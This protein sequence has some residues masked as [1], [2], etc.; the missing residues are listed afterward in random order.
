MEIKKFVKNLAQ[1]AGTSKKPSTQ[2]TAPKPSRECIN[3]F[4]ADGRFMLCGDFVESK[5]HAGEVEILYVYAP[6]CTDDYIGYESGKPY[7][8]ISSGI[9]EVYCNVTDFLESGT[10]SNVL[11]FEKRSVGSSLF[12]AEMDYYGDRMAMYAF[13]RD[14]AYGA[15]GEKEPFGLCI[16]Y[17]SDLVGTELEKHFLN[18]LKEAAETYRETVNAE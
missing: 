11:K 18:V 7:F 13:A 9:D 12:Y 16:V 10:V 8:M 15:D 2:T 3:D 1:A 6:D 17:G 14:D 4:G 5:S